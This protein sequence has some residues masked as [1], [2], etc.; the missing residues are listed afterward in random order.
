MLRFLLI[1]NSLLFFSTSVFAQEQTVVKWRGFVNLVALQDFSDHNFLRLE[2]EVSFNRFTTVGLQA[3]ADLAPNMQFVS[4]IIGKGTD[5][6]EAKFD[7]ML[8]RYS[9]TDK[10]NIL[11][12]KQKY[13]IWLAS[14][15]LDVGST[16][17]WLIPPTAVYGAEPLRNF[18]GVLVESTLYRATESLQEVVLEL[19]GGNAAINTESQNNSIG[20]TDIE[21]KG[22]LSNLRGANLIYRDENINFRFAYSALHSDIDYLISA[23]SGTV[24]LPGIPFPMT[25]VETGLFPIHGEYE[26]YSAGLEMNSDKYLF[27]TEYA[28]T[29][30]AWENTFGI[31]ADPTEAYYVTAGQKFEKI[32]PFYTYS[33]SQTKSHSS[34]YDIQTLGTVYSVN[35]HTKFKTELKRSHVQKGTT[36][37]AT[38]PTHPEWAIG[39]GLTAVF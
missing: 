11:L 9:P 18:N 27:M 35:D 34:R 24:F 21:T 19:Y 37:F 36:P 2:K 10:F 17:P 12:G 6:F 4:Q 28:R 1:I 39:V 16:Y 23:T 22:G 5:N 26:L 3:N 32:T 20:I 31:Q 29:R 38:A 8:I 13:P 15:R 7:W 33:K 14:D 25:G 30:F